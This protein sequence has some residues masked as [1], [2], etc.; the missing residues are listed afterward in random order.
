MNIDEL[1]SR[2]AEDVASRV[3]SAP[4]ATAAIRLG[5]HRLR[6][7]RVVGVGV[8]VACVLSGIAVVIPHTGQEGGPSPTHPVPPPDLHGAVW[9][10][11]SGIHIGDALITS[12]DAPPWRGNPEISRLTLVRDGVVYTRWSQSAEPC[13]PQTV[14]VRDDAGHTRLLGR[15]VLTSPIGD[16]LS[17]HVA[18]FEKDRDLVV[19]DA[20]TGVEVARVDDVLP[21]MGRYC[22]NP[23]RSVSDSTVTLASAGGVF[24][25]DWA[26]GTK[27][28]REEPLHGEALIARWFD[29]DA[30]GN[31]T[32]EF[33]ESGTPLV[34]LRFVK[35]GDAAEVAGPVTSRGT[36]SPD[37]RYYVTSTRDVNGR[38]VVLDP[39]TGEPLAMDLGAD[40][41]V[42]DW[43]WG[44]G[45][46][47]LVGFREQREDFIGPGPSP[48][49]LA[50][51]DVSEGSC[52][53][54][55]DAT[56]R[57]LPPHYPVLPQ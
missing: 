24:A 9:A 53:F 23:I 1:L 20:S 56:G 49:R 22:W 41:F 40:Y 2:A 52:G 31:E 36:F 6:R 46:T 15:D 50:V 27:P 48:W 45:D 29:V 25:F 35:D 7:R 18:W 19:M 28:I 54:V 55:V 47:L 43:G 8:A 26:A 39:R 37:G 5:A 44:V 30:I 42:T 4:P 51:C 16:R 38:L 17:N 13:E 32:G 11:I 21:R 14:F 3:A 12:P 57:P 33:D 10:D 34:M